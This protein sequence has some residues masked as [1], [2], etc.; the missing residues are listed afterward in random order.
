MIA[1]L[2][3]FMITE[4]QFIGK[5]FTGQILVQY[6]REPDNDPNCWCILGETENKIMLRVSG[7]FVDNKKIITCV[8]RVK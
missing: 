6:M 7:H 3:P 8:R 1:A 4:P 5:E 2:E